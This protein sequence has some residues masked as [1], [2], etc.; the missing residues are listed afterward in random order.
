MPLTTPLV[1]RATMLI[2]RPPQA[3]YEAFVDP[4][5]TTRF[6]FDRASG[7]LRVGDTLTWYWDHYG[8]SGE[9]SVR[10]LEPGRR[11]AID[12]PTPVEWIFTPHGADATFVTITASDFSGD[13]DARVAAALDA[14]EGFNL[15]IAACKAWLEHGVALRVVQ[16]KQP[17]V[18]T[19]S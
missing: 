17:T 3:V 14:T 18:A 9:V 4:Q 1:A 13:D 6:W 11:I 8:V 10:A 16:D 5:V 2:R 19:D 12:W 7:P 15:V